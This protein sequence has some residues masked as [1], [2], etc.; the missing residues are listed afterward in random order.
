MK[1]YLSLLLVLVCSMAWSQN[2]EASLIGTY[3]WKDAIV[4]RPCTI[5]GQ[6]VAG[7][8]EIT[9]LPNQYFRVIRELEKDALVI[10]ILKYS[11][12]LN[13][14]RYNLKGGTATYNAMGKPKD[15]QKG[16]YEKSYFLVSENDVQKHAGQWVPLR[17][18]FGI[19]NFPFKYRIQPGRGDFSGSFNFGAGLGVKLP[20][21]TN[22]NTTFSIL[23]GYSLSNVDLDATSV[24]RNAT[25]LNQ[26]NNFSA[27]S[28]SFG[29]MMENR[30]IQAGVFTGFDTINHINQKRFGWYYQGK[31][32]ISVG[33]GYAI[34]SNED[35]G[36]ANIKTEQ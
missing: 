15:L 20:H 1:N 31:P 19:I 35:P 2:E 34:F 13:F 11:S 21:K 25:E 29:L 23:N 14:V 28:I 32:W 5:T 8:E 22:S 7:S 17:F 4:L 16:I 26:T 9:S 30:R 12:E 24:R 33:F 10:E 27:L 3:F 18:A 6:P 36:G